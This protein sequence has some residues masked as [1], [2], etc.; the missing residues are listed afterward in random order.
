MNVLSTGGGALR[1]FTEIAVSWRLALLFGVP[2]AILVAMLVAERT[3]GAS[4]A[5]NGVVLLAGIVL[6]CAAAISYVSR[7]W[8]ERR[9]LER[10]A[11]TD[12]LCDLPNRRALHAESANEEADDAEL[13]IALID[14]DGF[15]LVNDFYGH[16]IGD[17]TVK[18]FAEVL[19]DLCGDSA[20]AYRLGGDEFAIVAKGPLAGNI[21]EGICRR[22]LARLASPLMV[23]HRAIGLG[24]SIGLARA[25]P[26]RGA[27]SSNLLRQ[28][29][30]ATSVAKARGKG[31]LT[32]FNEDFDRDRAEHQAIDLDLRAALDREELQ[33]HYQPLIDCTTG[34]V[35]A[36]EALLRWE[37][38]DGM[39][40]G[41]DKF[42]PIAEETGLIEAIGLWVLRRA[43]RDARDWHGIKV[44]VNVSV[45]QL[46]NTQFPLQL[47][48]I[49]EETGFPAERLELELTE[50]FLVGDPLVAGRNLEMLRDF[51]VGIVLD[52]YGTGYASIG[53][54]RR[55]RFEKLKLDRSLIVD[56]AGDSATRTVMSSSVEMAKAL[57]MQ[58]TAEGIETEL[59]ASLARNAGCDQMQGW[60][61]SKAVPAAD[62]ERQLAIQNE[63]L[64]KIEHLPVRP[65]AAK[66]LG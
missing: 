23:E 24:A 10:L 31:R 18:A 57:G 66:K 38:P 54:L 51:G 42:I 60:L 19:V 39:R 59:Q 35:S 32:W 46:R 65:I 61:Y 8:Q 12:S 26:G 28:A 55:F 20:R 16:S 30:V 6:Y 27:S 40:I 41:P 25:Q 56:A 37:R 2:T 34:R 1:R 17:R 3:G 22:V 44:S 7:E 4:R 11:L 29:D 36:V 63:Q 9:R 52:D 64:A 5:W 49:L 13:A 58:V 14:L 33:V 21:L 53:F 48:Q 50:T 62:L 45:A 15:K 43:C 47:G